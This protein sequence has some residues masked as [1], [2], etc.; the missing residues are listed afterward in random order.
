MCAVVL[1]MVLAA[2]C[3][4]SVNVVSAAHVKRPKQQAEPS[5]RAKT[6]ATTKR[7]RLTTTRPLTDDEIVDRHNTHLTDADYKSHQDLLKEVNA[8]NKPKNKDDNDDDED[9]GLNP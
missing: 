6:R 9:D 1:L 7:L 8:T 2:I 5:S 4:S 3:P